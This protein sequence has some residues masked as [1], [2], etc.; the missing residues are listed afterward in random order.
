MNETGKIHNIDSDKRLSMNY[1]CIK[2]GK[3]YR[4]ASRVSTIDSR[5]KRHGA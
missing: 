3:V 2:E 5:R 1:K 4:I